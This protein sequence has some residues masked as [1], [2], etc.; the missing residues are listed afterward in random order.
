MKFL[1]RLSNSQP[2]RCPPTVFA[3]Q[4]GASRGVEIRISWRPGRRSR[5][6]LPP[7]APPTPSLRPRG[8]QERGFLS[9]GPETFLL[10]CRSQLSGCPVAGNR[11]SR[12]AERIQFRR[13]CRKLLPRTW[14]SGSLTADLFANN[15]RAHAQILHTPARNDTHKHTRYTLE[16][17]YMC[18]IVRLGCRE[19]GA[20]VK[21]VRPNEII[22]FSA[23]DIQGGGSG[24][25]VGND[26]LTSTRNGTFGKERGKHT[27]Y[28]V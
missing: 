17:V 26:G 22:S 9:T 11:A 21:T 23:P 7:A 14:F 5:R 4:I 19:R 3:V 2:P 18:A 1:G 10:N 27:P 8:R 6:G 13:N 12:A 25:G 24:R 28:V 20:R 15:T 16:F